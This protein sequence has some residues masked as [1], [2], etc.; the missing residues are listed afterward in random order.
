MG[1]KGVTFIISVLLV[2][3]L[4]SHARCA[5]IE[6]LYWTLSYTEVDLLRKF[7]RKI[8]LGRLKYYMNKAKGITVDE[9]VKGKLDVISIRVQ[10]VLE[11]MPDDLKFRIVLLKSKRDVKRIF[12]EKYRK[13]AAYIAFY[14]PRERAVYV[15]VRDVGLNVLSHEIAHAV[16]DHYFGRK[17]SGKIHEVLAQ[18][19]EVQIIN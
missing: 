6:S 15:S 8:R 3:T 12:K 19:A 1:R 9:E 13:E 5:E 4:A 2:A 11:M 10:A 7:N 14:S 18:Y 16:I 17:P